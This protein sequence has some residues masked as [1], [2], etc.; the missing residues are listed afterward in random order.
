[1][2]RGWES[3]SVQDQMDAAAERNARRATQPSPEDLAR[4]HKRESL[5][6]HRTRVLRDLENCTDPRYRRTLTEG[7][8][9][10]EIQIAGLDSTI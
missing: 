9:Y 4:Q 7:L 3:K 5:L 6:L 1:M 10:L 8:A 2:A